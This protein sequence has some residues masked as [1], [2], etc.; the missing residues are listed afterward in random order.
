MHGVVVW[1]SK[2]GGRRPEFKI[3]LKRQ[4][5]SQYVLPIPLAWTQ[6]ITE[7]GRGTRCTE[8]TPGRPSYSNPGAGKGFLTLWEGGGKSSILFPFSIFSSPSGPCRYLTFGRRG[9]FL[10][11][12]R[13]CDLREVEPK[14]LLPF[15]SPCLPPHGL[16]RRHRGGKGTQSGVT[17]IQV[18]G[19]RTQQGRPRWENTRQILKGRD[20]TLL[21]HTNATY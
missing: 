4:W 20:P 9:N 8:E 1:G 5:G 21:C 11:D 15:L 3:P 19:Q 18:S 7:L 6:G 14:S 10:S 17:D 16:R 12:W 13:S 2:N